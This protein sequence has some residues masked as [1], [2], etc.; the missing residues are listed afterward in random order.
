MTRT[1]GAGGASEGDIRG[2]L[3]DLISGGG[4]VDLSGGHLLV[5]QAGTPAMTVVVDPGVGYIPNTDFDEFD[6]DSVRI[7][8]AVVAGLTASRTLVIGANS[9]GSTRIDLIALKLDPGASPDPNASNVATLEVIAGTPGAGAPTL[10]DFHLL[11]ASVSVANGASSIVNASITDSRVQIGFRGALVGKK[12]VSI[13]SSAT[14]TP[15][16]STADVYLITALAAAAALGAPTNPVAGKGLIIRI[17]DNGTARALTYNSAY[18]AIGV[19]LPP[20]TIIGKTVYIGG[21]WNSVDS[22]L[23]VV[24]VAQEA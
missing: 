10:P 19:T 5:H 12:V 24:A 17:K 7:W 3:T 2:D 4:V 22:K 15:D 18:R 21:I 8:E 16:M 20:T 13:T 6:S 11:L 9:S 23:D 1:A 14:P